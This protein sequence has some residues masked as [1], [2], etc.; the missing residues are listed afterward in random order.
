[1]DLWQSDFAGALRDPDLPVPRGVAAHPSAQLQERF[2]VYRN[3]VAVGLAN[4]LEARF[5]A[6]RKIA[7]EAFFKG[8]AKLFAAA[9]PPRSPLMMS[10]G[11][12]FP[13]F[14]AAFG[15]AKAVPYLADVA[16]LESARARAYHAADA[17]PLDAA[18]L[19]GLSPGELGGM[20]F[21]LHPSLEI[22]ASD[23]PIVAIWAMN[24]GEIPL[25]PIDDWH[26]EDALVLRPRLDV[27][28]RLLPA[29][30]RAFLQSLALGKPLGEAAAAAAAAH[31]GFDLAVN[32]AMLFAGLAIATTSEQSKGDL[33]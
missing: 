15:P 23:Y 31:R 4:A 24:V 17:E 19:R 30:A 7:G 1:M 25:A 20:R 12:D 32:L 5:P 6:T 26:G 27:E 13:S 21:V 9:N 18:A 3:N 16:R 10:Y 11:E 33:P 29:G 14:L 8:A 2:A 28:V 22:V